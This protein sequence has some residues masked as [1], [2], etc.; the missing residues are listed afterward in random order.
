ME[1]AVTA[2]LDPLDEFVRES[3][4]DALDLFLLESDPSFGGNAEPA[5]APEPEPSRAGFTPDEDELEEPGTGLLSRS[6]AEAF[7]SALFDNFEDS[8]DSELSDGPSQH[9]AAA[10]SP[11]SGALV[12]DDDDAAFTD[13][14]VETPQDEPSFV[15]EDQPGEP[16]FADLQPEEASFAEDQPDESSFAAASFADDQPAASFAEDQPDE[17]AF[18]D[19]QPDVDD[20]PDETSF[21]DL[22][23]EAAS[24]ADDQ[25]DETSFADLQPDTDDQPDETSFAGLQPD[26]DDQPDETSFADLAEAPAFADEL[27]FADD[28]P[29]ETSF[30]DLQPDETSFADLQPDE[31]FAEFAEREPEDETSYVELDDGMRGEPEENAPEPSLADA[32][33]A[34][35][36]SFPAVS[37][38]HLQ[39]APP[40]PEYDDGVDAIPLFDESPRDDALAADDYSLDAPPPFALSGEERAVTEAHQRAQ[41][42]VTY[43]EPLDLEVW[44]SPEDLAGREFADRYLLLRPLS[45]SPALRSYVAEDI[46][47]GR[48]LV[49]QLLTPE[50]SPTSPRAEQFLEEALALMQ[51]R[52]ERVVEVLDIGT[53]PDHLSYFV[54]EYIP[55]E[56]LSALLEREGPLPWHRA[57]SLTMQLLEALS[58]IHASGLVHGNL[59][60]SNCICAGAG[61]ELDDLKLINVGITPFLGEWRDPYGQTTAADD[62]LP[63]AAEFMAPELVSGGERTP[64]TDLYAAGALLYEMLSGRPPF[65]AESYLMVLKKQLYEEPIPLRTLAPDLRIP[66]ALE[67]VVLRALHKDPEYRFASA[68]DFMSALAESEQEARLSEEPESAASYHYTPV[69]EPPSFG[70]A[71]PEPPVTELDDR[72]QLT[73]L[74][75]DAHD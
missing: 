35:T 39:S 63:G 52:H 29:D 17:S 43:G 71:I 38:H 22:Q 44:R 33:T 18:A 36:A 73:Y 75:P 67:S 50:H 49:I 19:L 30:A 62:T 12:D 61:E 65:L 47:S 40:E 5:P 21:A 51:I 56:G 45:R 20:Q 68:E 59:K 34:A 13:A 10:T 32:V 15:V 14:P 24:F 7:A 11:L 46:N 48:P 57:L 16:S 55:G 42:T 64:Q 54:M 69:D 37:A 1:P 70:H 66:A 28:Q 2:E 9:E 31:S 60:P 4:P 23:P 72:D 53:T 74:E 3:E 26:T 8:D 58:G 41:E 6:P 27:A 25:P